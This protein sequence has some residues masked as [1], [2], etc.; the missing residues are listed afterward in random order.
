VLLEHR[1]D[2]LVLPSPSNFILPH[3]NSIFHSASEL[4]A[5]PPLGL[6]VDPPI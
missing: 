2:P 1:H 4:E 6:A 5:L 3:P